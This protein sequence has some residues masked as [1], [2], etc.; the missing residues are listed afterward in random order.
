MVT[1][2]H[3]YRAPLPKFL[4]IPQH[5]Y[6]ETCVS[7]CVCVCVCVYVMCMVMRTYVCMCTCT[8]KLILISF[9]ND[10]LRCHTLVCFCLIKFGFVGIRF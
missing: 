4:P 2:W 5:M 7:V 10:A 3:V 9:I 6:I 1:N 8:V